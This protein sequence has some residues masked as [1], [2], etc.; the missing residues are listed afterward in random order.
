[1]FENDHPGIV[2]K[3]PIQL[4]VAD[5]HRVHSSGSALQQTVG[6]TSCRGAY[7]KRNLAL[8][9]DVER[10]K[11]AFQFQGAA[12]HV[13]ASGPYDDCRTLVGNLRWLE[14]H[15]IAYGDLPRHHRSPRL[16]AAGE[17]PLRNKELV[18][19]QL[20]RHGR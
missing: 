13:S 20:F 15:T 9:I 1:F 6:K 18:K 11:G 14:R 3:L 8:D 16:F 7:I 5:V 17:E 4:P 19:S 2:A 10:V 12:A